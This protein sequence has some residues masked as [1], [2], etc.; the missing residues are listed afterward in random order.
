[1]AALNVVVFWQSQEFLKRYPLYFQLNEAMKQHDKL[2]ASGHSGVGV[3]GIPT[4]VGVGVSTARCFVVMTYEHM[5]QC[6]QYLQQK[7]GMQYLEC[8]EYFVNPMKIVFDFDS[9]NTNVSNDEVVSFC[10]QLAERIVDDAMNDAP[11]CVKRIGQQGLT[12]HMCALD[13]SS[14]SKRSMHVVFDCP[15]IAFAT[16]EVLGHYV[17]LALQHYNTHALVSYIDQKI[18]THNSCLRMFGAAKGLQE[19][20]LVHWCTSS[21]CSCR[22]Q[23]VFFNAAVAH[24]TASTPRYI[25]LNDGP[26]HLI[27]GL[28][29]SQ[30]T[31]T[32]TKEP[33]NEA[34]SIK[35]SLVLGMYRT[36]MEH[37]IKTVNS[38]YWKDAIFPHESRFSVRDRWIIVQLHHTCKCA[39]FCAI[40]KKRT[41]TGM[42]KSNHVKF[43]YDFENKTLVQTCH[44]DDCKNQHAKLA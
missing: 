32:K 40:K 34:E 44:D 10:R 3:F 14:Q 1:M 43:W 9:R 39:K 28:K 27:Q 38:G 16:P 42:H 13:A 21:P 17:N 41:G 25:V 2:L 29:P 19:R 37:L 11:S 35:R 8:H 24:L 12:V 6:R 33:L 26:K 5:L 15:M 20:P 30:V 7:E 23:D 4:N 36:E 18:Y 31:E 22:Y